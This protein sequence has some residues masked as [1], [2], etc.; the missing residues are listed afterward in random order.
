MFETVED[1]WDELD[2]FCEFIPKHHKKTGKPKTLGEELY[3]NFEVKMGCGRYLVEDWM[4]ELIQH[5]N[6]SMSLEIP[7]APNLQ[8]CPIRIADYGG[9]IKEEIRAMNGS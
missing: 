1:I 6:I 4:I 3:Y 8:E 5:I 7:V 9:I 2:K